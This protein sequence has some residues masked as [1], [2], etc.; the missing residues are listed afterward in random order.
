MKYDFFPEYLRI[1]GTEN[2]AGG[3]A[4]C[5]RGW[6]ARPPPRCAPCLMDPTWVPSTYS[7]HYALLFLP[8]KSLASSNPCSCSSCCDFRSPCAKPHSPNCF[9]EIA[10]WYVT[11]P[12]VQLVFALVPYLSCIFA[13]LVALFL[14]FAC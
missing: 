11:P 6:R 9:R 1:L 10:P 7:S 12:L 14:R 8:K 4:T 3:A 5:P 13:A 2:T